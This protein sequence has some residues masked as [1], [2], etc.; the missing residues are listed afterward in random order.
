MSSRREPLRLQDIV[1]NI[2]AARS[3]VGDMSVDAFKADRKTV[4]TCE[5]CLQR[6]TEAVIKIGKD[7]ME[8]IAPT[9]KAHAIRGLGNTLRHDYDS[10]DL[11]YIHSTIVHDLPPLRAAC[12]A[13]LKPQP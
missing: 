10:I 13:A 6:I 11:G 3:Y 1:E 2:D 5:R 12:V 7:R 4:D 9:I 8:E